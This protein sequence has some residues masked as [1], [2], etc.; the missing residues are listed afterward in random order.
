MMQSRKRLH[1]ALLALALAAFGGSATADWTESEDRPFLDPDLSEDNPLA[2]ADP[3]PWDGADFGTAF[4]DGVK[5]LRGT[6][7]AGDVD[8]YAIDVGASELI[9]AALFED[10]AGE[11]EDTTLGIFSGGA[12][13]PLASDDDSASGFLSGWTFTTGAAGTFEIGVTGFGDTAFDGSHEQGTAGLVPYYLAI[14]STTDPAP[15]Q[16]VE[17]NDTIPSANVLPANGGLVGGTLGVGDVDVFEIDLEVGD[18]VAVAI[19]DLENGSFASANGEL[20]D[21]QIGL[22]APG[23]G[24][25]LGFDDDSGIGRM[26]NVLLTVPGGNAGAWSIAVTGFGDDGF[27][28]DHDEAS[29]DYLLLVARDRACPNLTPLISGI[30]TSTAEPYVTAELQGGDH[31]YID[32]T[33]AGRHVL[34]DIPESYEC[35][36]WIKTAN[37]DKNETDPSHLTFTLAEDASVFVAYDTRATSEP[38]W[39]SSAFTPTGDVVD[40]A[41]PSPSQEFDVLRRDF[42]A[43][44]VV[45]GGND[46]PGAGS[47]YVVFAQPLPLADPTQAFEIGGSAGA[48]DV[49]VSG[50]LISV[51]RMMGQSN[52]D[53]AQDVADTINA[54]ATLAAARIYAL[55]S[56]A[57]VVTTGTIDTLVFSVEVP[58]LP[59][60]A[61]WLLAPLL[62]V[63]GR[64]FGRR[65]SRA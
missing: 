11:F 16:E 62:V 65:A 7:D 23:G 58:A 19:Y 14:A 13:P 24:G 55:A 64:A 9:L 2:G 12:A 47:N 22:F 32:R 3:V 44:T 17:S 5:L 8:A 31:Y 1:A 41:D 52:A 38:S 36:E 53:F 20:N 48:V 34:V 37:D 6:L 27:T 50:V 10:G 21:T 49:T 43:G 51:T 61:P 56:G 45:L 40:V 29:F 26:S 30:T 46:A 25:M 63:I 15:L 42:N 39:L 60:F 54:N 18:R 35:A 57:N 4:P 33:A 28:G 59:A